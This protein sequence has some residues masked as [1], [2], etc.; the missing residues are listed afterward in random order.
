[1]LSVC[2]KDTCNKSHSTRH[3]LW[4]LLCTLVLTLHHGLTRCVYMMRAHD[5]GTMG[6]WCRSDSSCSE[7]AADGRWTI[8]SVLRWQV[9]PYGSL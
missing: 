2:V 8:H 3:A 7:G 4:V 5:V 9:R 1:M 6:R